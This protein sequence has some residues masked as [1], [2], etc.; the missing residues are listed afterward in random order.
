VAAW[1]VTEDLRRE[2]AVDAEVL[3]RLDNRVAGW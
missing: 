1:I 2:Q 3:A